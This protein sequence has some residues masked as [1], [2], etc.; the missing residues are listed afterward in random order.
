MAEIE[1][2]EE[3]TG[4]KPQGKWKLLS[5]KKWFQRDNL[6]ILVL[7]GILLFIIA[8]PVKE[9][10][11]GSGKAAQ[12]QEEGISRQETQLWWSGTETASESSGRNPTLNTGTD[13][14]LTQEAAMSTEEYTR[15][16][17]ERLT[18]LLTGM[19]GAGKVKVMITLQA[20]EE[21]VVEKDG[22]TTRSN[23]NE[24]DAQ[25]GKRIVT[26]LETQNTTVYDSN[27]GV[28]S[29][30]VVK[31]ILPK[32]EGVVVSAEGAGSGTI[33]RS[34]VEVVQALFDVEAHKIKVVKMSTGNP[35]GD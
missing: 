14:A 28:S 4:K 7:S 16:L 30:Y 35:A 5:E 34:I 2:Q 21:L 10:G 24:E 33:N 12:D 17:E 11:T 22:N 15:Y 19:E 13:T 1:E 8:L 9:S 27:G 20:S 26:E 29:P 31:R 23:T 18:G 32:V 3:H 6:V 25:G